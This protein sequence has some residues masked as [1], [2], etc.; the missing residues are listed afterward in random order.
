[1]ILCQG[2][3]YVKIIYKWQGKVPCHLMTQG[4]CLILCFIFYDGLCSFLYV[5]VLSAHRN[6]IS[7]EEILEQKGNAEKLQ[8]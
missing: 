6:I 1:M 7:R 3:L 2:L 4:T 5:M 8:Y